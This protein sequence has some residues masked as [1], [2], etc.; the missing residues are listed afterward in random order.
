MEAP[1]PALMDSEAAPG[2]KVGKKAVLGAVVLVAG[3]VAAAVALGGNSEP[4]GAAGDLTALQAVAGNLKYT[5]YQ[6]PSLMDQST[7]QSELCTVALT[8]AVAGASVVSLQACESMCTSDAACRGVSYSVTTKTCFKHSQGTECPSFDGTW[9]HYKRSVPAETYCVPEEYD[10]YLSLDESGSITQANWNKLVR[11][12]NDMTA[13]LAQDPQAKLGEVYVEYFSSNHNEEAFDTTA[14]TSRLAAFEK[15]IYAHTYQQGGTNIQR[16]LEAVAAARRSSAGRQARQAVAV[17]LTDGDPTCCT[18]LVPTSECYI[19]TGGYVS[20][21]GIRSKCKAGTVWSAAVTPAQNAA[22]SLLAAP[23]T[24]MIYAYI[25]GGST[26]Q[27]FAP[28]GIQGVDYLMVSNW[29]LNPVLKSV[30]EAIGA[31]LV[32]NSKAPTAFPTAPTQSPLTPVTPAP[33]PAPV[34]PAPVGPQTVPPVPPTAGPTKTPTGAP[35][36]E[37]TSPTPVPTSPTPVPTSPTPAPTMP[38]PEPTSPTP[39]P[40][41]PF[42]TSPTPV[43]T[44]PTPV[45]TSPTPA[46]TMPT[47]E[48]TS[49]TPEPTSPTPEPTEAP[50]C[51]NDKQDGDETDV[52]CGGLVCPACGNKKLCIKNVD[53]VSGNCPSG[54]CGTFQLLDRCRWRPALRLH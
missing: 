17:L 1:A 35:T 47:P 6:Y 4:G 22:K 36:P 28:A 38:T 9:R 52:D 40:Q 33:T 49:P 48:P 25:G 5:K 3:V 31:S 21:D 50:H 27:L 39:E 8:A 29:D 46:P 15:N 44:S 20:F 23:N 54:T 26:D 24:S 14:S 51:V 42:P 18:S 34:T 32:C 43:P 53:C 37:P 11:F 7:F 41:T 30:T 12:V 13:S 19:T 16:A 2:R 10:L 45:P